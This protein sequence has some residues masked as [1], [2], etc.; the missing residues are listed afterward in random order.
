MGW[1]ELRVW[2][3]DLGSG[4]RERLTRDGQNLHPRWSP[5]GTRPAVTSLTRGNFDLRLISANALAAPADLVTTPVEDFQVEWAP[6]GQAI[7]FAHFSPETRVDI[8]TRGTGEA[9]PGKPVVVT[10]DSDQFPSVSHDGH[11]LLYRSEG[12]FYVTS[13]PEAGERMKISPAEAPRPPG[14]PRRPRSS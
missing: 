12:A 7:V 1:R 14:R 11:W 6:D 4:T 9:G 2:V 3:Y 5:D 8:W 10:P 13:F